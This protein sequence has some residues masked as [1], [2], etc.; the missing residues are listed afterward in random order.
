MKVLLTLVIV[1]VCICVLLYFVQERMMFFPDKTPRDRVFRFSG[2]F[3]ELYF[4]APDQVALHG[5]LFKAHQ[6]K[7]LIFY[8]HG[9]AGSIESWGDAATVYTSLGYDVF[10]LDYRGYGKS[11]GSI[12]S[13]Q[14]LHDDVNLVFNQ[15]TSR[16]PENNIVILGYSIGTGP[17][18]RLAAQSNAKLLI[19][20]SPF[21]SLESVMKQHYAIIPTFI[22]RYKFETYKY[23]PRCR[24]PVAI[25]HGEDDNLIDMRNAVRLRSLFKATDTLIT[26]KGVGHN[27]MT[28][29]LQ[30]L[31]HLKT[32]LDGNFGN[33]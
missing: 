3:E 16:Y 19:L 20:Q 4:T 29:D 28:H 12:T 21:Y 9:N 11:E 33:K 26:L 1:Y 30:Y 6:S 14:Q 10:M 13:E 23:L 24:M 25:F 15:L 7:G 2:N 32:I 17:A 22:L 31:R 5:V 18:V 8:L 27:G